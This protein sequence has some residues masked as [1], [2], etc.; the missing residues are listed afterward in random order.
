MLDTTRAFETP[1]G[2][3]L[4]L[5]VA[6]PVSRAAAF[7]VDFLIRGLIYVLCSWAFSVLGDLGMGLILISIFLIEWFYPVL[8]EVMRGATPGKSMF[9]LM[10]CQDNGTP[11]T[12]QSSIIRNLLRTADFLPA[13][14]A[15]GLLSM[16]MNRDFKR[17][18]DLVAGTVVVY[19]NDDIKRYEIDETKPRPLPQPLRLTEQRAVLNFAERSRHLSEARAA[20]LADILQPLTGKRGLDAKVELIH[21]ANWLQKGGDDK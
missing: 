21:F 2:I 12:W 13:F 10:V 5:H 3:E 17:L 9:N 15:A 7:M 18:G 19:R 6:G 20:E 14:Y 11:V 4:Q 16:F 1:E 8:F